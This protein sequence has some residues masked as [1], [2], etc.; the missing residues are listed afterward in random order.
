MRRL[1][2]VLAVTAFMATTMAVVAAPAFANNGPPDVPNNG[3]H[4]HGEYHPG[5]VIH[6][7][8]RQ[9]GHLYH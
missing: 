2:S 1:L 6:P 9:I 3:I 7:V 5:Q 4:S 8:D